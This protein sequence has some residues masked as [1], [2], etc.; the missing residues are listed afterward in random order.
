M[1]Q[2]AKPYLVSWRTG[3]R[4]CQLVVYATHSIDAIIMLMDT[5]GACSA[6]P[7]HTLLR[8]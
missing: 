2:L 5:V 3:K 1:S 6:R 4:R 8:G 7:A